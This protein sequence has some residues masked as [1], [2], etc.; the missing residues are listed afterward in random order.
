MFKTL[1]RVSLPPSSSYRKG[2]NLQEWLFSKLFNLSNSFNVQHLGSEGGTSVCSWFSEKS[3][4][5][6]QIYFFFKL[7]FLKILAEQS[8]EMQ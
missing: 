6:S 8:P 1:P 5:L 4:S 7:L 2:P 3:V